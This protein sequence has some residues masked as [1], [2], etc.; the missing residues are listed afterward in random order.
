MVTTSDSRL[1]DNVIDIND[2][3]ERIIKTRPVFYS[4]KDQDS[5][6]PHGGFLAQEIEDVIPEAIRI[7]QGS[8]LEGGQYSLHYDTILAVSVGAI[9]ELHKTIEEKDSTI[10]QLEARLKAIEEKL[11]L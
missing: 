5:K 8:D 11:G 4:W 10:K 1:K 9:Q 2:P 6:I 7:N 3:L